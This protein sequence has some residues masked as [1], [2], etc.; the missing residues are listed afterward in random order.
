MHALRRRQLRSRGGAGVR[1]ARRGAICDLRA[2]GRALP[3]EEAIAV[4]ATVTIPVRRTTPFP[5][6]SPLT[7]REHDV[8]RLVAAGQTDREIADALFLVSVQTA[9][10]PLVRVMDFGRCRGRFQGIRRAFRRVVRPRHRTRVG[11]VRAGAT[12]YGHKENRPMMPRH[13]PL[14]TFCQVHNTL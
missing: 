8:L 1:R 9:R 4:A 2:A 14:Q 13:H 6:A 12:R 3:L 5:A 7:A 11:T 10:D